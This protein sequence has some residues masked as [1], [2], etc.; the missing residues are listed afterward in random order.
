MDEKIILH[1][2]NSW[3]NE[4]LRLK[5][6]E[7]SEISS[8]YFDFM[9]NKIEA[10]TEYKMVDEVSE[11]LETLEEWSQEFQDSF[12]LLDNKIRYLYGKTK[13]ELLLKKLLELHL[14]HWTENSLRG[15]ML[16]IK[17]NFTA[18][19]LISKTLSQV[20]IPNYL[21]KVIKNGNYPW[22]R[23]FEEIFK[24]EIIMKI[25][26][27]LVDDKLDEQTKKSLNKILSELENN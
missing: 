7:R 22:R 20:Y 8:D 16:F 5:K 17:E 6:I 1:N 2:S 13:N 21:K 18:D 3:V 14:F 26:D 12:K 9:K 27:L 24:K 4:E 10:D 25:N 15:V 11:K 23:A 19:W